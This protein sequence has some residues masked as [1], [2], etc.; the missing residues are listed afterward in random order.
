MIDSSQDEIMKNWPKEWNV[1]VVSIHCLAYNQEKYIQQ[2]LDGF[3]LQETNFP[4]EVVVHDDASTDATTQIIHEYERLFPQIVKPI[5]EQENLFSKNFRLLNKKM[6]NACIGKYVA[7]CEGDDFWIRKDKLQRQVDFLEKNLDYSMVHTG[8][9]YFIQQEGEQF[10][11]KK[12]HERNI[13]KGNKENLILDILDN[14]SYRIQTCSVL[15]RNSAYKKIQSLYNAQ[16]GLF[17]MSDTQL[18]CFL[19]SV[20]KIH[21]IPESM[22]VYRR[23][24]NSVSMQ[25]ELRKKLR[26]DLSCC[27]MRVY[28]S[29]ILHLDNKFKCKM[30]LSLLKAFLKYIPF[31]RSYSSVVS[32]MLPFYYNLIFNLAKF[33][34]FNFILKKVIIGYYGK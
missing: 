7:V 33:P 15:Y 22:C 32:R 2:T 18:W 3:L 21:Y 23:N 5:Y 1:P 12:E 24:N 10:F 17:L 11:A 27:E 16:L 31:D 20:G 6:D 25:T 19:N 13:L 30:E 28:M 4:F 14:N 8:F 26:F 34:L 29:I 9:D